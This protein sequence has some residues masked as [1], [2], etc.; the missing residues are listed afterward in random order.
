V[1]RRRQLSFCAIV[2][3]MTGGPTVGLLQGCHQRFFVPPGVDA[4]VD[5]GGNDGLTPLTLDISVTG[6]ASFDLGSVACSGTAPLEVSFSPVGSPALT[7]FVWTFGDGTPP[8]LDRAPMHTYALPG[9]YDVTVTGAGTADGMM[10]QVMQLRRSFVIVQPVATGASCDVDGQCGDG[11]HCLCQS[12]TGC[13]S[14]FLRGICSTGCATGIC[15]A[16]ATC[17]AYAI[18]TTTDGGLPPDGAPPPDGGSPLCLA[19]CQADTDCAAG[20]V[21]EDLLGGSPTSASWVRGC[22]PRG[23]AGDLGSSCRNPNNLL[24]GTRCTTALCADL[25]TLG[26][27]SA[28]CDTAHPCPA[29]AACARLTGGKQLCLAACSAAQ[30]CT[31]DPTLRCQVGTPGDAATGGG[32]QILAGDAG[33]SY[34][35]PI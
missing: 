18:G 32:L 7:T 29:G 22:L 17:A 11:L 23:A 6:C 25:G 13:G 3:G 21:C 31:H 14:A 26:V 2:V 34:C 4:A 16:G 5:A 30:P 19:A 1:G 15:G 24:D 10:S 20:F 12:G 28:S 35:A 27:C 33:A 9:S 8:S